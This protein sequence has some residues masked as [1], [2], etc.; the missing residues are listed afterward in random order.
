MITNLTKIGL[1]VGAVFAANYVAH[2]CWRAFGPHVAESP[3]AQGLAAVL[4]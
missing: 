4:N 1:F 3:A 2:Y